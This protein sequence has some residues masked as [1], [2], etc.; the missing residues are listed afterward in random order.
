MLEGRLVRLRAIE[1]ADRERAVGWLNDPE[2]T[3]YLTERY[4]RAGNDG[5]WLSDGPA[6]G[7]ADLRLAIEAKDGAHIGAINLHRVHAEDRKAGLGI[8][9]GAKECWGR[10]YGADAIETLLRFAFHEMNLNRVWL[11][12]TAG[13]ERAIACYRRCGFIE[14][15]REREG[16][17]K[18]GRHWDFVVMGILRRDFEALHG[19]KGEGDA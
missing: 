6:P 2:V 18:H 5:G 7:F 14:E 19:A 12:V 11:T 8:I 4:G 17:Y 3:Y 16:F 10:G 15:A 1:P 13:H 9:I